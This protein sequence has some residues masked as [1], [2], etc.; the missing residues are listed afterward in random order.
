M[1]IPISTDHFG[2]Q[3]VNWGNLFNVCMPKRN[4]RHKGDM[5]GVQN[6]QYA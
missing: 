3:K 4:K 1:A 5:N 2:P 6:I